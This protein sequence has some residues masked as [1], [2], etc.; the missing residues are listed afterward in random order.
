M[1]TLR[2]ESAGDVLRGDEAEVL[3]ES[4]E[5]ARTPSFLLLVEEAVCIASIRAE[6]LI[7]DAT[8]AVVVVI[9]V[10]AGSLSMGLRSMLWCAFVLAGAGSRSATSFWRGCCGRETDAT[11]DSLNCC[12]VGLISSFSCAT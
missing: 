2:V 6:R 11:G 8:A 9:E 3:L 5:C 10:G 1:V 4:M 7:G 12:D